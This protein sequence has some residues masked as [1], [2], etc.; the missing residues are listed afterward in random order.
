MGF[1]D[2]CH[3]GRQRRLPNL[4]LTFKEKSGA[5]SRDTVG[6]SV[7]KKIPPNAPAPRGKLPKPGRRSPNDQPWLRFGSLLTYRLQERGPR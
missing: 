6:D 5:L 3:Q 1:T 2:L 7:F 4:L